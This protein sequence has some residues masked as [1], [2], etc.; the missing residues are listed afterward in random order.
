M[1]PNPFPSSCL[2]IASRLLALLCLFCLLLAAA[3]PAAALD[4][5]ALVGFG[6][7][8]SSIARYRQGTWN[9][10]TVYIT[11]PGVNGNAQLHVL[12]RTGDQT[13]T[14]TRQVSLRDV[15]NLN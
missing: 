14:Y 4:L 7:S 15:P 12:V 2:K 13:T 11:G 9:P 3:R 6:Q 1:K 10:L 5:D 8:A